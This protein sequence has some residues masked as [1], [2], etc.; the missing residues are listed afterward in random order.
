PKIKFTDK[1][2]DVSE[3]RVIIIDK[4][5]MRKV[6]KVVAPRKIIGINDSH[7][8]AFEDGKLLVYDNKSLEKL[9]EYELDGVKEKGKYT[10]ETCGEYVFVFDDDSGELTEKIKV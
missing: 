5:T 2:N 1:T 7:F 3:C 9:D 10:F 6:C 4:E 8:L